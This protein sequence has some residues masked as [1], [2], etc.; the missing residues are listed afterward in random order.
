MVRFAVGWRVAPVVAV[1]VTLSV[2]PGGPS[3][4]TASGWSIQST[5]KPIVR[6]GSLTAVSCASSTA[7]V[8][9]GSYTDSYAGG[10]VALAE[11]WDGKRWSIQETPRPRGATDV[12]FAG[13]SCASP[14]FCTAVG[15]YG[16]QQGSQPMVGRWDGQR[17]SIQH[18]PNPTGSAAG[19]QLAAVSC[20][21]ATACIAVG[22]YNLAGS[23]RAAPLLERWDGTGWSVQPTP[24]LAGAAA[25]LAGVSCPS[26]TVC[27]AVGSYSDM[28]GLWYTLALRWDGT[29]W[30]VEPLPAYG[31]TPGPFGG[32]AGGHLSGVSCPSPTSCVA[33]GQ[34]S[35][36]GG[37]VLGH[38]DGT[39]WSFKEMNSG[40]TSLSDLASVSCA[41]PSFCAAVGHNIGYGV[42]NNVPLAVQWDGRGWLVQTTPDLA[43][44]AVGIDSNLAGV[45]CASSSTCTAVGASGVV[46]LAERW[47]GAR[48]SLQQAINPTVVASGDL[49]GVSC[50][51]RAFC[52]AV[53]S[54]SN[55]AGAG[56]TLVERW[57]GNRWSIQHTPS[58]SGP[59]YGQ[60]VS[61][62]CLSR[63]QTM[64]TA[65]GSYS[66][67]S[68]RGALVE[69][70]NGRRWSLQTAP[71][72][73]GSLSSVSCASPTVC[74][75]V[76]T[77]NHNLPPI[78]G[79]RAAPTRARSVD[80]SGPPG[81]GLPVAERWDGR[82]WSIQQA[83]EPAGA[84]DMG[85]TSV[86]C[87]S[88]RSCSAIGWYFMSGHELPLVERWNGHR[89]S[90]Q[91][92]AI[93]TGASFSQLN[94]VAC[95]SPNAC[96]AVGNYSSAGGDS[97]MLVERWNGG[98]W[99][100]QRPPNPAGAN[101]NR[102]TGVSCASPSAC[103]AV[104]S[105]RTGTLVE[106]WNGARWSIQRVPSPSGVT[107]ISVTA[108]S[109]PSPSAC[110]ALG[111]Y[112]NAAGEQMT[113][114]ERW[115]STG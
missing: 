107:S 69:R 37:M 33:V 102:L 77:N 82:R 43:S 7:C 104:G 68:S 56:G 35:Y 112:T 115:N 14:T 23:Q 19:A 94:G 78:D 55:P 4:A 63:S 31:G 85:L 11:R 80:R 60:L 54:Y 41:S 57:S 29:S 74:V 32:R 52:T 1:L 38:W 21:S 9:V 93:P 84:T 45:S 106:R 39:N 76:A 87:S 88:P 91:R 72:L 110:T 28:S 103:T 34:I 12:R 98:R 111:S 50:V 67:T 48:W 71:E 86:S 15:A 53:G 108:V 27:T 25:D 13:V 58:P 73:D 99:S 61:V 90:V 109:C 101:L 95:A 79:P 114:V 70:W 105:G 97:P 83:P 47:N 92:A 49:Q 64:C 17:W 22:N 8:A 100:I 24:D 113:L 10:H 16:N 36:D 66:N 26:P 30:S 42:Y 20:S 96:T 62:S 81:R 44:A 18:A 5:P 2:W 3:A 46:T 40:A 59:T 6:N 75:A 51:S 65:V 89:W